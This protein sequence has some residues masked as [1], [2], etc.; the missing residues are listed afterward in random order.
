MTP[1]RSS[2]GNGGQVGVLETPKTG[3]R[4]IAWEIRLAPAGYLAL[5]GLACIRINLVCVT[6]RR[7][8]ACR[9]WIGHRPI[10]EG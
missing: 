6:D 7:F 1:T 8:R 9:A 10:A 2:R 4:N 3:N 5:P